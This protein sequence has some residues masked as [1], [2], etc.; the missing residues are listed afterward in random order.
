VYGIVRA[1]GISLNQSMA[2]A[3]AAY[4][5]HRL[6]IKAYDKDSLDLKPRDLAILK[7]IL[8]FEEELKHIKETY[9]EKR[10]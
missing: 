8:S 6:G 3:V 4:T 10:K 7:A 9:K 5:I 1:A 2:D